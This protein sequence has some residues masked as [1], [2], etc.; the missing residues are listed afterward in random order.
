MNKAMFEPGAQVVRTGPDLPHLGVHG[1]RVYEVE[2]CDMGSDDGLFVK[3][4]L[5]GLDPAAFRLAAG[6]A[7]LASAAEVRG[8]EQAGWPGDLPSS[9]YAL[10]RQ[11]ADRFG[12]AKAL[13]FFLDAQSHQ[14]VRSWTFEE[15]AQAV[16]QAANL[17]GDLGAGR[18]DVVALF[19]PNLPEML[20]CLWGA[21]A[22]G[23]ALPINPL[24][25]P[26]GLADLLRASNAKILV[27]LAPLPG[28][29]LY[30]K[31]VA[32]LAAAPSVRELVPVDLGRYVAGERP[33]PA[34]PGI[35]KAV[36]VSHFHLA[37]AGQPGDRL[38][39]D[40]QP[41]G[42]DLA[43]LFATGGSTGAPKLARRTHANEV[44]N[45]F[46]GTRALG[47]ALEPGDV[48]FAGLPLFHV[49]GAMVTGLA[50]LHA[51][52]HVLLASPQ[53]FRGAGVIPRFWEI[54]EHH[55]VVMFSAVPTLLSALL[56]TPS[57]GRDLSALRFVICG[58]APLS[59]ELIGQFEAATGVTIVEGYGLTEA[60]CTVALNP[61]T[62]DRRA[63]SVGLP[64]PFQKVRI[65]QLG[66]HGEWLAEVAPG[67]T[68]QVM[69]AG[70][71][72]F[73]G[74]GQEHQNTGVF[75]LDDDG[76]RWLNTGDLGAL[77]EDGRLWLRGRSKDV[78][79]RGGHNIDPAVIEDA[80]YAHPAVAL[81]AAIGR[82]DT[83]AGEVPVVYVELKP[84]AAAGA[85]ELM[86]FAERQISER[87]ARP[88]AVRIIQAM[89]LTAVG[90]VFKPALREREAGEA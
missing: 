28:V 71:N 44:A 10:I 35:G 39:L 49:N 53:G 20:F 32:A 52:A 19:L 34:T 51:G 18:D 22:V 30:D 79:I 7:P 42:Q 83:H 26:A 56:L 11:A 47:S 23:V 43:S 8:V 85:E 33:A 31:A 59:A 62:G 75:V 25:E 48:V 15:Y 65:A 1:G 81:A 69:L 73:Q 64:L 6:N 57:E 90:K 55:R 46:M 66:S 21:E 82:A 3:G 60:T 13:S 88:K 2:T 80:F 24:L 58:A 86:A 40:R 29:D 45:A 14:A 61:I 74:Y 63:G 87:A 67:Q 68:G 5:A 76:E 72:I 16:T 41:E 37:C 4:V 38:V 77:D 36:R 78:I 50:S 9:T 12:P 70:P 27:T 89:P 54:V 17:F 84:G